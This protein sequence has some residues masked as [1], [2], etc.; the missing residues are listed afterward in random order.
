M[1]YENPYPPRVRTDAG[2]YGPDLAA[3]R[4]ARRSSNDSS[5]VSDSDCL[6]TF[7]LE[8]SSSLAEGKEGLFDRDEWAVP[9]EA[10]GEWTALDG[11]EAV[12]KKGGECL[13][14]GVLGSNSGSIHAG[15]DLGPGWVGVHAICSSRIVSSC[16]SGTV[17]GCISAVITPIKSASEIPLDAGLLGT[18]S[19]SGSDLICPSSGT[20][21]ARLRK[22]CVRGLMCGLSWIAG[23]MGLDRGSGVDLGERKTGVLEGPGP[24]LRLA[25]AISS[26]GSEVLRSESSKAEWAG[27]RGKRGSWIGPGEVHDDLSSSMDERELVDEESA[28]G[29]LGRDISSG[30]VRVRHVQRGLDQGGTCADGADAIYPMLPSSPQTGAVQALR[31]EKTYAG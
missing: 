12:P 31:G 19:L 14:V 10:I 25:W 30:T 21:T 13:I 1:A 9:G 6:I 24:V 4:R 26:E 7:D 27:R 18:E 2:S 20:V 16:I 17:I 11:D 29:L 28:S 22:R 23:D 15:W 3:R 5:S 8:S